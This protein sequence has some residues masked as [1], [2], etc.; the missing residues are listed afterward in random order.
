MKSGTI[1]DNFLITDDEKFA[2]EFGNDTWGATK[3]WGGGTTQ[4]QSRV[5]PAS[6]G[7]WGHCHDLPPCPPAW[8]LAVTPPPRA[9]QEAERKMKEAQDEEQRKKQEEED[10]QRKEEEGDEE[11]D[12]DD[13]EEEDD[14]D[15]EAEKDEDAGAAPKDEL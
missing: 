4:N 11:G 5:P 12:A 8:G 7:C 14:E 10:K 13:D 15:E 3:V 9:P 2:E 1:F 6:L